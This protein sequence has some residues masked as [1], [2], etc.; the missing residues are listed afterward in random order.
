MAQI[1]TGIDALTHI[2]NEYEEKFPHKPGVKEVVA[3]LREKP[4][5]FNPIC[6]IIANLYLMSSAFRE[7][8]DKTIKQFEQAYKEGR[9]G[10]L[11]EGGKG[12]RRL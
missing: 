7:Q 8:W 9:S 10:E 2:L 1:L 11:D 4:E 5:A 12:W 3:L 6:N